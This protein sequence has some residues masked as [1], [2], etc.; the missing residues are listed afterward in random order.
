LPVIDSKQIVDKYT[1]GYALKIEGSINEAMSITR[2]L[3][4]TLIQNKD[5]SIENLNPKNRNLLKMV[6]DKN[7]DFLQVW[8]RLGK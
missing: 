7:P 3:A 4:Y 2:T 1:N 6:L 8:F 5:T